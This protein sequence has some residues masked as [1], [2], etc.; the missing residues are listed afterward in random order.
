MLRKTLWRVMTMLI[1]ISMMVPFVQAAPT[2]EQP[3]APALQEPPP[4]RPEPPTERG[5]EIQ[6]AEE[7][8]P[9]LALSKIDP[10][11]REAAEMGG[12][13]LIDLYVSVKAG[14]DLSQYMSRMYARPVI[15]GGTQNVYGQTAANNLLKIAQEPDVLALVAFG[16]EMREKPYDPEMESAPDLA[17]KLARIEA[18]RANELTYAEAQAQA[19]EVGAEGW[20]DVLDG[21]QSS[22]AWAK[23]FTGEGV[24]VGVLDDGIDFAHPDLQGTYATVT[25]P[26]SPYYGWPMAFSQV[27]VLYFWQDVSFGVSGIAEG[28]AGSRWTDAQTTFEAHPEFEGG[29]AKVW[30]QPLGSGIAHEYTIPTTSQSDLY[31][32]GSHPDRNLLALY[33]ERVAVLVVDEAVAGAY[34]TVY[35]DLDN[36]YDFTDE[37][38]STQSSPEVYRD[39]DGDGYADISG[40]ALVWISD[41]DN[42]PPTADWLWGVT[43]AD[44]S[45]TMQGCPDSGELVLFT[46]PFDS[47]YTHGTQCASNIAG[48][49]MVNDGL[50]AQPFR[51]GGMVQGAAPDVGLMDF[52][53]H[54][55]TGTDEDEYLVA[56]LGYDG[57]ANSGDEIQITSNSYGNFQQMWGSWGYFGRLVTALNMSVAPST[58]WIFSSGNEG[59]GYGPE[60]GDGG[61]T[62]IMA[63]SSTQY[64]STNW[65][66]ISNANQI[67]YGDVTAFFSKG[68]NRDGSSGLDVLGNGGRGSGDEGINYYGYNGAESWDTW[69]G[70]SR[71]APVVAGNLALVYQAYRDRYGIWPTWDVAKAL[72]KSGATNPSSS[73]FYQGAGV[74]NA[75]RATDLAAGIYGVYATPDEWQVGDWEGTEYLNFAKVAYPGDTFTKTYT[76]SNPSGYDITVDLS[77]GV[78]TLITSTETTFT[79]SDESEESSFN[80]HSPDYLMQLDD[81]LIPSDAELMV[82]RYVHP[83]DTFD[84]AYDYTRNP[85]SSWR[86]LLYNWTDV[87]GDGELWVD[88]DGNGVVNHADDMAAG[89][90]NDGFYRPDYSDPETEIQQGEYVRM[91]YD[92]GGLAQMMIV[93]DPI[94]RMANGYYFGF[95]HRYNDGTV[96]TTTFKIALEFYKRADWDWLSLSDSSLDVPAEDTAEF[97]AVMAVPSTAA[98]GAYEGVIF[99]DDPGD[100]HHDAHETALPVVVNVIA[101]LPDGD[102]FTLG[103][104]PMADTLYQNSWTYGYFNWYGGGW[105][106][107]GDWRHYFFD[108]DDTDLESGNMLI[109]TS[110]TV[111]PT[112]FNTWVLGP[113]DDC[114]SN[115]VGPCA[116]FQPG[117]GQPDPTTFGPYTLQPIAN[118]DPFLAGATYPF[119]TSTGGPDDWLVASLERTGLHEIALHNVLYNGE[120]LAEQFQVDVG[121]IEF[122]VAMDPAAG[123]V[124]LGSVDAIAYTE[125]GHI[126]LLFTPSLEIPDLEASLAG[127]LATTH[128]D[129]WT[130]L[131]DSDQ[132]GDGAWCAETQWS[133]VMVD[134]PG[135]TELWVWVDVPAGEDIDLFIYRDENGND[136]PDQGIDT[137]VGSS[138]QPSGYDDNVHVYNPTPGTYLVGLL[139]WDLTV[140]NLNTYWFHELTFPGGLPV[141]PAV[142][143]DADITVEQDDQFDF[144]TASFS[145]T[146]TMTHRIAELRATLTEVDPVDADLYVTDETGAVVAKSQTVGTANEA[147]VLTP[148]DGEYRFEEGAEYTIWVHGFGAPGTLVMPPSTAHLNIA[149]DVLNLWLSAEHPDVHAAAIGA[150]ETV[151]VEL[152]FDRPGWS[153]G[154][155]DLSARLLASPSVVPNAF[156]ELVT[157]EREADPGPPT[158][159]PANLDISITAESDRGASPSSRWNIGG[160]PIPTALVAAGERVT[161]T[162][163]VENM[164]SL[165]SPD[166]IV[167]A[168]PLP[169]DYV[170][171]YFGLCGAYGQVDGVAYGLITGTTGT[172]D[173]GGG[174]WWTGAISSRD[175]IE[176][177]YWVEMPADMEIGDNHTSGVDVYDSGWSWLGWALAGG[178]ART[179]DYGFYGY[180]MP[181]AY[182]VLPGE[183]FTYTVHLENYGAEDHYVYFSDPLPDE[184]TYVSATGGA[185]YDAGMHTVT[186]SGLLPGTSLSD[187]E[188]DIVVT[189]DSDLEHDTEIMNEA[190]VAHKQDGTPFDYLYAYTYVDMTTYVTVDKTVD[191]IGGY[192]GDLL[193][194]SIAMYNGGAHMATNAVLTD[195]IPAYLTVIT[196]S[197]WINKGAG[198]A[199]LPEDAYDE[200]TGI[201]RWEDELAAGDTYTITFQAT[202]D[203]DAPE[204][205]AIINMAEFAADNAYTMDSA[206]TEVFELPIIY[207]PLVLRNS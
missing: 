63:G 77:D 194:F 20:F 9:E 197:L 118:S 86:F 62:T 59:P 98:P 205:W 142:V 82:V 135:T 21:H 131:P 149:W 75:D 2:M 186:W 150:G 15:F 145:T 166:L 87:N 147:V 95:Q 126:D 65:D 16:S 143:F 133:T 57:I 190:T 177:G 204:E 79:T 88:A 90:D 130:N 18:L 115:G 162:V 5:E 156:D 181:S 172:A 139:G 7:V 32:M 44:G 1:I 74:V 94:E 134:V 73:P 124:A 160:V 41:G 6:L 42:P 106:G 198:T 68:P 33:G 129:H 157:I 19:G 176:F 60:E 182:T 81:S 13:D 140:P 92:F 171:M 164:D 78:M 178:Y 4:G 175:S 154:D 51:V 137:F 199:F 188:F 112:D 50:T 89:P 85:N 158:W 132:C 120:E 191:L 84:P 165:D 64:G 104:D 102:A 12:K 30:Y 203:E 192:G 31:K 173:Y 189:A 167:D 24:I 153:P 76:V 117:M 58:V 169:E 71:S 187:T 3:A 46:G 36:D 111:T 193:S 138:T 146:V 40:G 141:D 22:D 121:T 80:F 97:D 128:F 148:P 108:V 107:A 56:A 123:T 174:I 119:H 155:P 113:T 144:T 122:D 196:D 23:G 99:M 54:Y 55:Y 52:G 66:S 26:D 53:N 109:H 49:G 83:Y 27:S 96:P 38:P 39:M 200:E 48:Q 207:L 101:D 161:Y 110:W 61:P 34:D 159:S 47:G 206:L 114:A 105:T 67:V 45:P 91:D 43:C 10:L 185:T 17:A 202:I 103:G 11:L 195:V 151:T 125:T 180:K 201:L 170:C 163:N 116:W 168:W 152:H 100:G 184:V 183:T 70:T 72:L 8:T 37:K 29:T 127:G 14:T 136:L 93:R 179:F 28:W 25:D 35:V 69:G